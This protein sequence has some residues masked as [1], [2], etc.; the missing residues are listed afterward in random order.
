MCD[1]R[2]PP[3]VRSVRIIRGLCVLS[4]PAVTFSD[5]ILA[6][7]RLSPVSI[8]S[9]TALFPSSTVPSTGMVSPGLTIT[10]SPA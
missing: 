8:D 1:R 9:L 6:T 4:V 7:G 5:G 2:V 3:P 10:I